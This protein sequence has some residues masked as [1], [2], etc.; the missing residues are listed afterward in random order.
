[1]WRNRSPEKTGGFRAVI[2]VAHKSLQIAA[3]PPLKSPARG[4]LPHGIQVND[5]RALSG[6]DNVAPLHIA[7]AD[8]AL[9]QLFQ[10]L[11]HL[12]R[13]IRHEPGAQLQHILTVNIFGDKPGT[14]PQRPQPL[15]PQG[16]RP[17]G[18]DAIYSQPV[19]IFP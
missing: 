8:A 15:F 18:G 16:Y 14:P 10:Q 2:P 5:H 17:G 9:R 1:M 19:R 13:N 12:P 7:V 3:P 4:M 11:K 6:E